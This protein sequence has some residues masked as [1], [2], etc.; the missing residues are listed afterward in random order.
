L[1]KTVELHSFVTVGIGEI[2]RL[3]QVA[4]DPIV[5]LDV[6]HFESPAGVP[7]DAVANA[8]AQQVKRERTFGVQDECCRI[9]RHLFERMMVYSTT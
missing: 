9:I 4:P 1:S 7:P 3:R 6:L 5:F 2:G 8:R